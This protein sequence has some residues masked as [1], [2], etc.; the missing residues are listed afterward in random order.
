MK[1]ATLILGI[2]ALIYAFTQAKT[3][4][5]IFSGW[6]LFPPRAWIVAIFGIIA[7]MIGSYLA[8]RGKR[9]KWYER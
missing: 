3:G 2:A 1:I 9:G 8:G 6:L 7:L 4:H 5:V